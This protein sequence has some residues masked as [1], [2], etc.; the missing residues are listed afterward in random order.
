MLI[1]EFIRKERRQQ[2]IKLLVLS[3][4]IGLSAPAISKIEN[5]KSNPSI[6]TVETILDA[7]GFRLLPI[8][9]QYLSTN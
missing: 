9:K 3:K 7:L 5:G 1:G 6:A 2:R 4:R 8:P